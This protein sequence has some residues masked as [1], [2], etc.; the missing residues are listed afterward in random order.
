MEKSAQ[1]VY[2]ASYAH[3]FG[4]FKSL[5]LQITIYFGCMEMRSVNISTFV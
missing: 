5:T 2:G 1:G 3:I 4:L